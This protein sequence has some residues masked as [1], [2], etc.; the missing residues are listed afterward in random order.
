MRR[1]G[2]SMSKLRKVGNKLCRDGAKI[3]TIECGCGPAVPGINCDW[4][5]TDEWEC[6]PNISPLA[7]FIAKRITPPSEP[8]DTK[9]QKR[10]AGFVDLSMEFFGNDPGGPDN[11]EPDN[12]PINI[13][14][15]RAVNYPRDEDTCSQFLDGQTQL[16]NP[17]GIVTYPNSIG[18][19]G[20]RQKRQI[21]LFILTGFLPSGTTGQF[22]LIQ[23]IRV[24]TQYRPTPSVDPGI[25]ELDWTPSLPGEFVID[26]ANLDI[27]VNSDGPLREGNDIANIGSV[28]ASPLFGSF[29]GLERFGTATASIVPHIGHFGGIEVFYNYTEVHEFL[30][31]QYGN[32]K[33][34]T[35]SGNASVKQFFCLCNP[36]A[37]IID[38]RIQDRLNKQANGGGC[39]GCGDGNNF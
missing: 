12:P 18:E 26:R 27:Q 17:G 36:P 22:S 23:Q 8:V 6:C 34:A 32:I 29:F 16:D 33:N 15:G 20:L 38:P 24:F 3:Q 28:V 11:F 4:Q 25:W 21:V 14:F 35:V 9:I 10:I 1:P 2:A 31:N 19:P 30:F 5:L 13:L 37:G 39:D 7:P